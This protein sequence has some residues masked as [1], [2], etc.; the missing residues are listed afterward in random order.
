MKSI[1]RQNWPQIRTQIK[2]CDWWSLSCWGISAKDGYPWTLWQSVDCHY[3]TSPVLS[4]S[5][6]DTDHCLQFYLGKWSNTRVSLSLLKFR[7][8]LLSIGRKIENVLQTLRQTHL[9]GWG[10]GHLS[11]DCYS[12]TYEHIVFICCHEDSMIEKIFNI[13]RLRS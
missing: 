4:P 6:N 12:F 11:W 2:M 10:P 1:T 9:G 13:N 5:Q 7:A 8:H 3:F